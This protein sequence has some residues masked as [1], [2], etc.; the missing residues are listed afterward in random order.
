MAEAVETAAGISITVKPK[1][2]RK[3][4]VAMPRD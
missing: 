3:G 4:Q 2:P 1:K